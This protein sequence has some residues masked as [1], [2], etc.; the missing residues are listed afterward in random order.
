MHF[1]FCRVTVRVNANLKTETLDALEQKKKN[2][3]LKAFQVLIDGDQR[4]LQER[5][6]MFPVEP[7]KDQRI[8]AIQELQDIRED[9][10]KRINI[11]FLDNKIYNELVSEMLDV[12]LWSIEQL[13]RDS[14]QPL[15]FRKVKKSSD[16]SV[17][18]G[19]KRRDSMFVKSVFE[20]HRDV[21]VGITESRLIEALHHTQAPHIPD[22]VFEID[23]LVKHVG[24]SLNQCTIDDF[25]AMVNASPRKYFRKVSYN[26]KYWRATEKIKS[27]EKSHNFPTNCASCGAFCQVLGD[28]IRDKPFQIIPWED[29]IEPLSYLPSFSPSS[30]HPKQDQAA[31]EACIQSPS[32]N[33]ILKGLPVGCKVLQSARS[34]LGLSTVLPTCHLRPSASLCVFLALV[35]LPR[36][37][38]AALNAIWTL[39]WS[40]LLTFQV[41]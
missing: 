24:T 17:A 33:S 30:H 13:G 29:A 27:G 3:H 1:F 41:L 15:S 6:I 22:D 21:F 31:L 25:Y 11:D 35:L 4:L 26:S 14:G 10:S 5:K 37:H 2:M 40:Y 28:V 19:F 9:Q 34:T 7:D 39:Q 12:H 16:S 20:K 32:I 23:R 36:I 18:L 8:S 38:T